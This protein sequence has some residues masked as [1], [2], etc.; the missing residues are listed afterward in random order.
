MKL[1]KEKTY[2][3]D[4]TFIYNLIFVDKNGL[5][6]NRVFSTSSPLEVGH[7]IV[8]SQDYATLIVTAIV[9]IIYSKTIES[10]LER[11]TTF[12]HVG[13]GPAPENEKVLSLENLGF[14]NYKG[15][16]QNTIH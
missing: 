14:K 15:G 11:D 8:L 12:V 7:R 9:H 13:V 4:R 6:F 10:C 5:C 2:G 16:I 1:K 3:S